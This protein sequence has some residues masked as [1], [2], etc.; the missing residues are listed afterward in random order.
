MSN[1]IYI[2]NS[3]KTINFGLH[4][5][6]VVIR[7]DGGRIDTRKLYDAV[8]EVDYGTKKQFKTDLTLTIRDKKFKKGNKNG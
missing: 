2:K 6:K 4:N 5:L 8:F 1:E 3:S 7:T